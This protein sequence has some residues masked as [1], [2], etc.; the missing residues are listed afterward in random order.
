L[1]DLG[2]LA[3][4]QRPVDAA[5]E[6][7]GLDAE[8][9]EVADAVLSRLGLQLA[10]GGDVGDQSGVDE[11]AFLRPGLVGAEIV[12]GAGGSPR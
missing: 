2:A 10:A 9:G 1:R 7:I 11:N 3:V 6:Q 4:G 12:A 5:E 8:A